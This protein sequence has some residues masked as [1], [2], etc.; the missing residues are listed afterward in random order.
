MDEAER[1]L[2]FRRSERRLRRLRRL[3]RRVR[4]LAPVALVVAAWMLSA[5]I[6]KVM[7]VPLERA[8]ERR[9]PVAEAETVRSLLSPDPRPEIPETLGVSVLDYEMGG[10]PEDHRPA[11]SEPE[12]GP[13][14][15]S[16]DED[17]LE[18]AVSRQ[19]PDVQ[20]IALVP[21]PGT[22]GLLGC[23]G[24]ARCYS[25]IAMSSTSKLSAAPGGILGGA[26][27]SP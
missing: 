13:L 19:L 23:A 5:G 27:S 25:T 4:Q 6:V 15:N 17:R 9:P 8:S 20:R 26:P 18:D 22:A 21:E 7:E 12:L 10:L 24:V 11:A 14:P 1:V 3:R 16:S 2:R